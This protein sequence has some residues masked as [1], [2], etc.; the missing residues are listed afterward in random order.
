MDLDA[1]RSADFSLLDDAVSDWKTMFGDLD[2]LQVS[3]DKGLRGAANKANWAGFNA[4]VSKEFIG[5]TTEEFADAHTQAKTIHGIL[6]DTR[7]ELKGYQKQLNEAIERGRQ[8]N[9]T[10]IG[11]EGGF[12]VTTN[13][14]PEGRAQQDKDNSAAITALRDEIQVILSKADESDNSASTVLQ[15]IADQSTLGFSDATYTDRDSAAKAIKDAEELA[16]IAK[17]N[18]ENL[19]TAE[20]D[21]LNAGLKKYANDDL[22]A[23]RF[24]TSLGAQ[25]TLDFWADINHPGVNPDLSS[26]RRDQLDDLQKNLSLTLATASQSDSAAMTDWKSK[27]IETGDKP[28]GKY[29]SPLG[30][31]VMSN[32][33]R[34]GDYDDRFLNSYGDKLIETEK[35]FTSNGRHGAWQSIPSNPELNH[36]G[37]D[38]GW[39]PVTGY[40]KGLSNSPDAA[41]EFF[42]D[43]FVTKDEDHDFTQDK[44][45]D[46]NEAK[47]ILSNFDYLFEERD[48]PHEVD[49]EGQEV[50]TGRNNL[51]LA[52]EAATTGHPAGEMPTIDTPAHNA[53]QAKLMQ[54]L[55]ASI[56]EDPGRL[57]G[58][59]YMS[60]SIGQITSE[61]L[62]DI[63]RAMTDDSDE[64][65][66]KLFPVAGTAASLNH[67]DVTALL[68]S[69]GQN[70]EGYAAVEVANKA[71]MATLMDYHMNPDLPSGD[72]Y[73]NDTQFAVEQLAH[74]SGEISGTLAI[75]RQEAVAGPASE[76]DDSY[77]HAVS[78]WKNGIS[79]AVGTGI[80]VGTTF[81]A[82]P[83]GG[84]AAGGAAGTV[85]SLVLEE[86]FQNAEG[87][88]KDD[89][90]TDMGASWET[91]LEENASYTEKAAELAAKV[92]SRTDLQDLSI[93]EKA[94]AAA[95]QGFRDAGTNTEYMA[96]HLKTDV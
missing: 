86:L 36:L 43:T 26:A 20:F 17:K 4:A 46:G 53:E 6:S 75:G 69:V 9:L 8:K 34:V 35:K 84:A 87:H 59:G 81:I 38:T 70:P 48:W 94:R 65:T 83:I 16:K 40:L 12:T 91:S 95:Q 96:P 23:E 7:D 49:S 80:G 92:H 62:P 47:R 22:F 74:G 58:N 15:A 88:A 54:S 28:V 3:A 56:A 90:G 33:M 24:A 64:D 41:T 25:G 29:G 14:P 11:Y 32:L 57:T 45:G 76:S 1:L 67:R 51:A 13:V 73:S 78:Q 79:G 77:D 31:Q 18:P 52:L 61:Y 82:S 2:D 39:D 5:K 10:V 42:N 66:N 68:V 72:K 30:F 37:G 50:N 60:D 63:N 19:T 55:V 71:Y 89:A 21:K 27:L 85:T 44:D 93:D